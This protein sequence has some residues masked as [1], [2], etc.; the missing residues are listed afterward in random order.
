MRKFT[1]EISAL[2]AAAA[3]GTTAYASLVSAS[4]EPEA[5][6]D[7][8]MTVSDEIDDDTATAGVPMVSDEQIET[9]TEEFFAGVDMPEETTEPPM[10]GEPMPSDEFIETTTEEIVPLAGDIAMADGDI[11]GD[12][13]FGVS[14]AVLL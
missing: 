3:V 5:Q 14:D 2:L 4:S 12:G 6:I 11:N 9:T 7:G 13:S 1:K 10:A 8:L